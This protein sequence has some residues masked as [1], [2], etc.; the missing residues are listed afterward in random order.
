[1]PKFFSIILSVILV[2][3]LIGGTFFYFY[4]VKRSE[5]LTLEEELICNAF[6]AA[7]KGDTTLD[8]YDI[9][10]EYKE[11]FLNYQRENTIDNDTPV[12]L[13]ENVSDFYAYRDLKQSFDDTVASLNIGETSDVE[14]TEEVQEF[15]DSFE[16]NTTYEFNIATGRE[17]VVNAYVYEKDNNYY[18]NYGHIFFDEY[19]QMII[20]HKGFTTTLFEKDYGGL[21]YKKRALLEPFIVDKQEKGSTVNYLFAGCGSI[22]KVLVMTRGANSI[23]NVEIA[24]RSDFPI[25]P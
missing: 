14:L 9:S 3:V 8:S 7:I 20:T 6:M 19:K 4:S 2:L 1:M 11:L 18:I 22:D 13:L 25:M 21:S 10:D 5:M 24:N 23:T 17:D 15:L 16:I 12:L